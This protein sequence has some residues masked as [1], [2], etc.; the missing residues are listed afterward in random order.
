MSALSARCWA[1]RPV[2]DRIAGIDVS[3]V[4]DEVPAVI[5]GRAVLRATTAAAIERRIGL[6]PLRVRSVSESAG[7]AQGGTAVKDPE[8]ARIPRPP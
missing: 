6:F 8:P 7:G 3:S 4:A 1:S 5:T 2:E